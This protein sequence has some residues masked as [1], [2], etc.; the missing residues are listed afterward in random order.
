LNLPP[1]EVAEYSHQEASFHRKDCAPDLDLQD[2]HALGFRHGQCTTSARVLEVSDN[3]LA[4][5]AAV[6]T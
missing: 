3:L 6:V 4:A 1:L 2:S 5:T